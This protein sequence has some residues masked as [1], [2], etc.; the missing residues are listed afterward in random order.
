MTRLTEDTWNICMNSTMRSKELSWYT[1]ESKN[2]WKGKLHAIMR[3]KANYWGEWCFLRLED[4]TA[5]QALTHL[6][7]RQCIAAL[8]RLRMYVGWTDCPIKTDK[9]MHNMIN[10]TQSDAAV[11]LKKSVLVISESKWIVFG[12]PTFFCSTTHKGTLTLLFSN[13]CRWQIPCITCFT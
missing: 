3:P 6:D 9:L 11:R 4:S 7:D 1:I 10:S 8:S 12:T 5:V 13:H 2:L